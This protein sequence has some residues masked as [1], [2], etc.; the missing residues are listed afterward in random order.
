M[1]KKMETPIM[2]YIILSSCVP[3]RGHHAAK[4]A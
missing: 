2:G 3:D 4:D 1:E